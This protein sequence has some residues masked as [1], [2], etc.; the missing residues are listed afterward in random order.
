MAILFTG[1]LADRVVSR[2]RCLFSVVLFVIASMLFGIATTLPEMVA[3]RLFQG[4]AGAFILPLAQTVMLDINRAEEH[5]SELQSLMRISYAVFCLKNK[6]HP[7]MPKYTPPPSSS[8]ITNTIASKTTTTG[9]LG[10][11]HL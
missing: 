9:C 10:L 4:V 2:N 6:I 1:W 5:T 11:R 8:T 7:H 3:F